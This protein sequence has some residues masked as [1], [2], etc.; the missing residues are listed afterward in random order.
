MNPL[1]WCGKMPRAK[2]TVQFA[3]DGCNFKGSR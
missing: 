2:N 1:L 3:V